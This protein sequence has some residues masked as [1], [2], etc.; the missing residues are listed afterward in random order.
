MKIAIVLAS[1]DPARGGLERYA[2][3]WACWAAGRG[4][5]VHIVALGGVEPPAGVH[6]H[7]I[8]EREEDVIA[9]ASRLSA[10][11][12][13]L[14]PDIVHDFS[15]GLGGDVL[16]PVAGSRAAA[17][18][19][20]LRSLDPA[21]RWKWRLSPSRRRGR[22]V[23]HELERRQFGH[24]RSIFVACSD[25]VARDLKLAGADPSR[26]RVI[27]NAVDP[28]RFAPSPPAEKSVRRQALGMPSDGVLFLQVAQ[29][30]RLKGVAS[31]IRAIAL[32][33]RQGVGCRLAIAGRGP[34]L[35]HYRQL[36]AGLGIDDRCHFLGAPADTAPVYAAADALVHPAF[37]DSCS[38]V[39]LEA[40]ASGLPVALSCRDGAAGLLT[41]GV[42]G[43]LIRDPADA[44]E[45]S[46]RLKELIDP[47]RR[48]AMGAQGRVLAELNTADASFSR[49][50][51]LCQELADAKRQ[52]PTATP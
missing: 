23:W 29:N 14:S 44:S 49:L 40:W 41:E 11:A 42:Q 19:G 22:A 37:Y 52:R 51:A 43:W 36:A 24:Q 27:Y 8:G 31:S 20:E 47:G 21:R 25:L 45:I 13:A 4:H 33:S 32:L 38:L 39:S 3:D 1:A 16:H 18:A 5:D 15:V 28:H 12:A 48:E 10:A 35:D 7:K 17:G 9:R 30:F 50:E 6:L 34:D 2:T 46:F 26:I